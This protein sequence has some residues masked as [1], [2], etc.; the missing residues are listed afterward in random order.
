MDRPLTRA[1]RGLGDLELLTGEHG[2]PERLGL[3][4]IGT[5]RRLE[6]H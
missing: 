3:A 5:V 4:V 2:A 6:L 1:R